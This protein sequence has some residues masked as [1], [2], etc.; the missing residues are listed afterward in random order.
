MNIN[1]STLKYLIVNQ[2]SLTFYYLPSGYRIYWPP[3]ALVW[4]T[5]NQFTR[6]RI[7]KAIATLIFFLSG[8]L[9]IC[10]STRACHDNKSVL[11]WF[12]GFLSLST[13]LSLPFTFPLL[14]PLPFLF[15]SLLSLSVFLYLFLDCR[16]SKKKLLHGSCW[17]YW[18]LRDEGYLQEQITYNSCPLEAD[19]KN[20]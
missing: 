7:I 9:T 12:F 16:Y 17:N 19:N 20:W 3:G 8:L 1:C 2:N 10:P 4:F 6:L 13:F 5:L 15:S 18:H 14:L 11:F